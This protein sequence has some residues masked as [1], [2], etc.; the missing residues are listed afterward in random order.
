MTVSTEAPR[1]GKA[2][3][4]ISKIVRYFW[5]ILYTSPSVLRTV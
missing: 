3:F 5:R 2:G 1:S 4:Y